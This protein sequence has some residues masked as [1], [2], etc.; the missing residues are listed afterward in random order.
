[1]FVL[2]NSPVEKLELPGLTVT[3]IEL[4]RPTAGVTFDLT[5]SMQEIDSQLRRAFEYNANLF[6]AETIVRMV[7]H[8]QTLLEA[9]VINPDDRV[10]QLPLLTAAEQHQLLVEWNN[11]QTDYPQNK[12]VHELVTE[13]A[14]KTP[15]AVAL[16][17]ENQQLTYQQLNLQAN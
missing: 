11:T 12:C 16:V 14:E 9:I 2:Q 15:D 4:D 7:D 17:F 5:L 6:N 10:G 3:Q 13:Q 8:F 1:M